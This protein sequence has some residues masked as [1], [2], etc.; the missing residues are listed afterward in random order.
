[1]AGCGPWSQPV[2]VMPV[3]GLCTLIVCPPAFWNW[4]FCGHCSFLWP[5]VPIMQ[6][7]D[8][9]SVCGSL[10]RNGVAS[11]S[12][13][14]K[15]CLTLLLSH[16]SHA[17]SD[18][19]GPYVGGAAFRPSCG[20]HG[21]TPADCT[22]TQQR[23]RDPIWVCFYWMWHIHRPYTAQNAVTTRFVWNGSEVW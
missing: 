2:L 17:G 5:H 15:W 10:C 23:Q 9:F 1:M 14:Q 7:S 13:E 6:H 3:S 16:F 19:E 4:D 22:G 20:H 18:P 11:G 8:F 12:F 21:G